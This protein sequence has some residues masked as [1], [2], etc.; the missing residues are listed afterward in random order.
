MRAQTSERSGWW[1][2][3]LGQV[4]YSGTSR[5]VAELLG[6]SYNTKWEEE[7]RGRSRPCACLGKLMNALKSLLRL[8]CNFVMSYIRLH[9]LP[10]SPSA[11]TVSLQATH[12][13][14]LISSL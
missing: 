11:P 14:L 5:R 10:L 2:D 6:A 7:K 3:N 12:T 1:H 13:R 4:K 8:R 9:M